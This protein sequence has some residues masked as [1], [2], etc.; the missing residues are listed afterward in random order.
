MNSTR[1]DDADRRPRLVRTMVYLGGHDRP[2]ISSMLEAGPDAVCIDLEDSTPV[3]D[4]DDARAALPDVAREIRDAGALVFVRVNAVPA[5]VEDD[6]RACVGTGLHCLNIPKVESAA[7][8]SDVVA[9]VAASDLAR[10]DGDLPL[11][12]RPVIETPLGVVNAFEIA[13]VP[14]IAPTARIAYMGGVEGGVNG[15]LGGALGYEQTDDGRETFYLRSKVLVEARAANVPFPIGGG[16]TSRRDVDGCVAFARENRVLGYSGV[17]CPAD[18]EVVRAI[19]TALTP[20]PAQLDEWIGIHPA[21]VQAR[22][23]SGGVAYVDGRIYDPVALDRI[24]EQLDLAVRLGLIE[25][26]RS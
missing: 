7:M 10:G 3:A 16:M 20:E 14:D 11:L 18:A 12:I 19:N 23:N 22:A 4:K 1:S 17:H 2:R 6:I 25:E 13:S 15:D 26:F 9:Q 24:E 8:V 5:D 21:L